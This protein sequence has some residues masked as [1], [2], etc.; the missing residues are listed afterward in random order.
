MAEA[1]LMLEDVEGIRDYLA[2]FDLFEGNEAEGQSYLSLA[3]RRFLIT[4][5][6]IPPANPP[7]AKLLE[8]GANPYFVTL[9]LDKFRGYELTLANYFGAAGPASGRGMQ[10][11]TSQRYGE[12]HVF[13]YDHF[14]GESDRF[15]Y[16][17]GTFDFVLNCE[18]LEHLPLDPTH[19]LCECHRVLKPGG[20]LLLTTPNVLA[21][22]NLWRLGTNRNIFDL[23]SGY[24]VYGR[25][26]RE[27]T[28]SELVDLVKGC[29]YTVQRVCLEDIYPHHGLTRWLK[30]FRQHWRDNL[31]VVAETHGRPIY[32]YPVWLYRSMSSLRRVVR[33]DIVMGENDAVQLGEGWYPLEWLPYAAR[34][35]SG[36]AVAYL[37]RPENASRLG[38]EVS[39][40]SDAPTPATLTVEVGAMRQSFNV[41]PGDWQELHMPLP[42]DLAAEVEIRLEIAPIFNP[43]QSGLSQDNR[44]LGVLVKRL[45]LDSADVRP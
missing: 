23:Y 2:S 26:N 44:N 7:G 22:Q 31:F 6:L 24:G 32:N 13:E 35:T 28:P 9:L 39:A 15:P 41:R 16:P 30:R 17:D 27:Y 20:T 34:W 14:N 40:P 37:L 5:S 11:V 1:K 45:W 12:R 25:H 36:R 10:V 8:L 38:T 29:G 3:L 4:A 19:Y 18:I 21:F 33:P 42:A 43:S